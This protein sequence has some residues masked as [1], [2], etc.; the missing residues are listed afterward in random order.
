[1][2]SESILSSKGSAMP[3]PGVR[4]PKLIRKETI[5]WT[6]PRVLFHGKTLNQ[7]KLIKSNFENQSIVKEGL[8]V[9]PISGV[10]LITEED[11]TDFKLHIEAWYPAKSNSGIYLKG[12]YEVQIEDSFGKD[13]GSILFGGVYGFLTPNEIAANK[14]G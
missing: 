14:A 7:W 10:N 3:F 11:F 5:K 2:L 13:P 12:R 6:K 1:M 4:A 9:N 8:L